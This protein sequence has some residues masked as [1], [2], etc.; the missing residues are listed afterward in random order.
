M[1]LQVTYCNILHVQR[2]HISNTQCTCGQRRHIKVGF[3]CSLMCSGEFSNKA[4][5]IAICNKNVQSVFR[6]VRRIAKSDYQLVMS[7]CP[8][9]C[10]HGT[11]R[12]PLDGSSQN[13]LFHYFMLFV[14]SLFLHSLHIHESVS[15]TYTSGASEVCVGFTIVCQY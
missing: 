8:S 1:F 13:F 9:V 11:T 12:L 2:T 7:V 15:P 6:R 14:P 4:G 5:Q 3:N 10:P